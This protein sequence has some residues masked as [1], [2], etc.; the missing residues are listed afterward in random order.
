MKPRV[1]KNPGCDRREWLDDECRPC[2]RKT[3][4]RLRLW[5]PR[6]RK[7]DGTFREVPAYRR[8]KADLPRYEIY[9]I[10]LPGCWYVGSTFRTTEARFKYHKYAAR[11]G[12]VK[13]A[14]ARAMREHGVGACRVRVLEIGYGSPGEA[15]QRWINHYET[16]RPHQSLNM[17]A[18][19]SRS[20]S[21]RISRQ[22]VVPTGTTRYAP[23]SPAMVKAMEMEAVRK[24]ALP[25]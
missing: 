12:R 5:K 7:S 13:T 15:E 22:E 2:H 16:N 11:H 24:G 23:M 6:A 20:I 17:V 3:M 18:A 1:C 9:L 25:R 14:L 21:R 19:S 8:L 4:K 10:A